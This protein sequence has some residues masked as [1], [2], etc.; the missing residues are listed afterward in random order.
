MLVLYSNGRIDTTSLFGICMNYR[1]EDNGLV[2]VSPGT[3]LD[4]LSGHA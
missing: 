3:G 4:H 2:G 1:N